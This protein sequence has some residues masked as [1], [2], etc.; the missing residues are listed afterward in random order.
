MA[1]TAGDEKKAQGNNTIFDHAFPGK[2]IVFSPLK[3]DSYI[4][5]GNVDKSTWLQMTC[6][7][8]NFRAAGFKD[9][10]FGKPFIT[11]AAPYSN[12]LPCNMHFYELAMNI[13]EEVEK[14]GGKAF[15]SFPPVI[16]DGETNGSQAM[17]YS[18][19]SRD[20]IADV[21]E[22]MHQGYAADAII[23]LGGCDKSVPGALMPIGRLNAIGITLYGGAAWPGHLPGKRGLDGGSVME[24]IGAYGA[25][26]IDI[27]ELY[28][29][30]CVALPGAGSCSAMFTAC[31]MAAIIEALGMSPPGTSSTPASD[32]P[33]DR[34][35]GKEKMGDCSKAVDLLFLMMKHKIHAREIMTR[36][37]FENSIMIMYA[38]GGS[39]NGVLHLLALA[40]ECGVQLNIEDFNTIG[41]RVPL[42]ANMS[43]HGKWHMAD[44]HKIGGLPIVMKELLEEGLLHGDCLTVTGK[45]VKENLAN[46][47][48]LS[49]LPAQDVILSVQ[50]PVSQSG[51]HII[52]LKGN[53]SS[54]SALLK[55][56]GKDVPSFTGP[57]Q[58]YDSEKEAYDAIQ[59]HEVKKGSVLVIRYE[60]PKG[61]PGMPEMLSPGAALVG[62]NLG[63]Y[64]ALV[65]DGRFSGASRGIMVGH[66]TPEAATGGPIA[67]IEDGDMVTVDAANKQLNVDVSDEELSER[68]KKWVNKM[69]PVPRGIL[70]KYRQTVQSAHYGASTLM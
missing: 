7:R 29:I 48:R 8:A 34:N 55:L 49:E 12:A 38:L 13:K 37:A 63:Q 60:G 57:A 45:T 21:I 16:S 14:R 27:E 65:T 50:K 53:V 10:D 18:L 62:A 20:Y 58:C 40:A 19:V 66:V 36:K 35:A 67:L 54:E 46:V 44:L 31:T 59:R 41:G 4:I 15:V 33:Q 43:P 56:S 11:I 68:R 32:E 64:V 5:H 3:Q 22:L 51:R 69:K 52:V 1:S 61:S 17:K 2:D 25:G 47:P 30:E 9:E 6:S 70:T 42:L 23:T 26:L 24:A 39:T 28:K